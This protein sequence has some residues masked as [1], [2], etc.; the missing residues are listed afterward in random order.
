MTKSGDFYK[1]N[2]YLRG[3]KIVQPTKIKLVEPH[4][5]LGISEGDII[6]FLRFKVYRRVHVCVQKYKVELFALQLGELD[7]IETDL[8]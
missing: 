7:I 8:Q 5:F 3:R 2:Y 6:M 4:E 1:K